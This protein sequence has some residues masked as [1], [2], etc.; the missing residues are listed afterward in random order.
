MVG[1][2][3]EEHKLFGAALHGHI[4]RFAPVAV[5]PA[6][7]ASS[8]F[9]WKVLGVVNENVGAFCELTDILIEDRMSGL[10]V[11][12]VNDDT[13]AGF[14]PKT[15]TALRVV[16]PHTLDDA[17]VECDPVFLDVVKVTMSS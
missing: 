11:S 8:I 10:V 13:F 2:V 14:D 3:V 17:V 7:P 9:I 5:A 1:I 4:D 16:E 12:G 15:E 6:S